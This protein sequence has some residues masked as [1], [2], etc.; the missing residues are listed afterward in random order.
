MRGQIADSMQT[1]GNY[2][3]LKWL[4]SSWPISGLVIRGNDPSTAFVSTLVAAGN[5]K[6]AGYQFTDQFKNIGINYL[7]NY[8]YSRP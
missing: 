2:N 1:V 4:F 7:D 8:H 5:A 6:M 3:I